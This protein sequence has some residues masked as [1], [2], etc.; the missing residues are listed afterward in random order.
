MGWRFR[1]F[2]LPAAVFHLL[3]AVGLGA[4]ASY[5]A[6]VAAG[7][8]NYRSAAIP[9]SFALLVFLVAGFRLYRI[10]VRV[11]SS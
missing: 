6:Y 8:G 4:V 1:E 7:N 2:S 3:L 5:F 9:G 10:V 11:R